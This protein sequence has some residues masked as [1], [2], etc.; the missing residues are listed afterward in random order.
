MQVPEPQFLGS[1]LTLKNYVSPIHILTP[2]MPN[3]P[4]GIFNFFTREEKKRFFTI[5]LTF[6]RSSPGEKQLSLAESLA[7][8]CS[9]KGRDKKVA[10]L[11]AVAPRL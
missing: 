5:I 8:F 3:S 9:R 1:S 6:C 2:L 11:V 7:F 4:P 10:D